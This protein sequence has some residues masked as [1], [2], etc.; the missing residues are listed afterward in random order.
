MSIYKLSQDYKNISA[1]LESIVDNNAPEEVEEE[2][3]EIL[4]I[5]KEQLI[6][7]A[8]NVAK[9]IKNEE[10]E[11]QAIKEEEK[12][13]KEL[14]QAREKTLNRFKDYVLQSLIE[15]DFVKVKTSIGNISIRKNKAIKVDID[16]S[17]L[18][19]EFIRTNTTIDADKKAL[20]EAI[21]K[22]EKIDG[23][24]LVENINLNIR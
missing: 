10:L 11:I 2:T 15:L 16:T 6:G 18:P 7:K 22:G 9:Y 4:E 20:K 1:L 17:E 19:R 21:E 13:L 5:V 12:R 3:R 23:V 24:E 8:D 14:R